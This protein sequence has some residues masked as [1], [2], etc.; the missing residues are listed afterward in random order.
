MLFMQCARVILLRPANWAKHSFGVWLTAAARRLHHNDLAT[1]L[2][3]KLARIAWTVSAQ[4]RSY[5]AR[6]EPKDFL[7]LA[8]RR[9][10]IR[11]WRRNVKKQFRPRAFSLRAA[12]A[13]V[14]SNHIQIR[15]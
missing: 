9:N 4:G 13:A 5:E 2:A 6:V 11:Y 7:I 14:R 1:A 12:S 15:N 8:R 10:L 3:N